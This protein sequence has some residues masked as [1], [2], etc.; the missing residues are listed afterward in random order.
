MAVEDGLY[1]E[2]AGNAGVSAIVG[3]RIYPE[4]RPQNSAVPAITYQRV[5]VERLQTLTGPV[6]LT[7][8]RVQINCYDNNYS[9]VKTLS[10]AV[11]SALDGVVNSLGGTTIQQA[12]LEGG[13]TD[14][15][16][17]D[18]DS[19]VRQVSLDFIIVLQEA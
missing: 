10:V 8:V 14:L 19:E 9:G 12:W 13:D 5:S 18:G 6:A 16:V 2:L 4:Q 15:G 7:N 3:T 1:A 11:R 17:I